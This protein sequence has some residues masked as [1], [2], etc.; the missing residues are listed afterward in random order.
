MAARVLMGVIQRWKDRG[1]TPEKVTAEEGADFAEG[2]LTKLYTD[3]QARLITLNALTLGIFYCIA[4]HCLPAI[5]MF[6]DLQRKFRYLLLD[7]YQ[8][9]SSPVFVVAFACQ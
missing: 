1:L 8:D 7:E 3:Y 2:T 4:L 6:C 9:T 5:P